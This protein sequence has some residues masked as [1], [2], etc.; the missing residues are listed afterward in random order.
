MR[1]LP[2]IAA[3]GLVLLGCSSLLPRSEIGVPTADA[4]GVAMPPDTRQVADQEGPILPGSS[5]Q[6][7]WM[8]SVLS[9]EEAN[10]HFATITVPNVDLGT[11]DTMDGNAYVTIW[12]T[13]IE[14]IPQ[15]TSGPIVDAVPRG[16]GSWIELKRMTLHGC[17]PPPAPCMP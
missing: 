6:Y 14:E 15:S 1:I 17:P 11:F 7:I 10:A 13:P 12:V 3:T 9:R 4:F 5:Y 2:T 8:A 16:W